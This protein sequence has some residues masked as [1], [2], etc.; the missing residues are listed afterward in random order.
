[1]QSMSGERPIVTQVLIALNAIGFLAILATGGSLQDSFSAEA[2]QNGAVIAAVPQP[3]GFVFPGFGVA[4]GEWW[5]LVSSGFLHDGLIHLGMNMLFLWILGP[6]LERA[7][8]RVNFILIYVAGLVGGSVGALAM[9]PFVPTLG[10]SGAIY[11]LLGAAV[12]VQR[13]RGINPWRSGIV[14]L[15]V[16]NLLITFAVP[17]ISIGGHLGGL[18][19]GAL[20]GLIVIWAGHGKKAN[21]V[22]AVANLG[23]IVALFW[24]GVW[25]AGYA[26]DSGQ[27]LIDLPI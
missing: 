21:T 8:G 12:V 23:L 1:M 20:A 9:D 15:I 16:L 6:E 19:G 2:F 4:E 22:A 27:G 10:A 11:G 5:R 7:V 17:G 25:V 14:G 13:D 26:V 24:V 18:I 3:G